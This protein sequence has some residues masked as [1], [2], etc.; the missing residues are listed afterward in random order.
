ML[1]RLGPAPDEGSL[2]RQAWLPHT[3]MALLLH[4]GYLFVQATG[5]VSALHIRQVRAGGR[6]CDGKTAGA[7]LLICICP[8]PCERGILGL[9]RAII[10]K[11]TSVAALAI[12]TDTPNE[13]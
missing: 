9:T 11:A 13:Q 3:G 4:D 5:G 1:L 10:F 2:Y 8:S 7:I 6:I 12:S